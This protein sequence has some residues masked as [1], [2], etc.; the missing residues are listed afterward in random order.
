MKIQKSKLIYKLRNKH[1]SAFPDLDLGMMKDLTTNLKY[2]MTP[3]DKTMPSHEQGIFLYFL[4]QLT[5]EE[6]HLMFQLV[7]ICRETNYFSQTYF[8]HFAKYMMSLLLDI[9]RESSKFIYETKMTPLLF[10]VW[11]TWA[12]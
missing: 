9:A 5:N 12:F 4:L 6:T 7:F 8:I 2:L 10:A 11:K 1:I 3:S